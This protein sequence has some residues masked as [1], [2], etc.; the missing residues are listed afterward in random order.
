MPRGCTHERVR[1]TPEKEG[2]KK[3]TALKKDGE[4]RRVLHFPAAVARCVRVRISLA[5]NL[6]VTTLSSGRSRER[7]NEEKAA[8]THSA[9]ASKRLSSAWKKKNKPT[10]GP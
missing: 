1:E 3:L 9:L 2:K 8:V 10:P 6:P 5:A 4:K 7:V